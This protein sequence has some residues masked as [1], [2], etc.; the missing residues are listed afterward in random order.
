M[1]KSTRL[2]NCWHE[3]LKTESLTCQEML[4]I[5]SVYILW[6]LFKTLNFLQTYLL[7]QLLSLPCCSLYY[8]YVVVTTTII[9][10]NLFQLLLL[11]CHNLNYFYKLCF[12]LWLLYDLFCCVMFA[13]YVLN[14]FT[15]MLYST[16]W[17]VSK[18]DTYPIL[19]HSKTWPDT[20][21]I[22]LLTYQK[23]ENILD[24]S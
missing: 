6:V 9:V 1:L 2:L 23:F 4:D 15:Y 19:K 16:K 7:L 13:I 18:S 20:S 21:Q 8:C 22:L 17:V 3:K 14:T 11:K 12:L 24:V 10:T 5:Y